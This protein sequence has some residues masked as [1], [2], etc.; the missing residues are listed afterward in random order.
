METWALLND[1]LCFCSERNLSRASLYL[2]LIDLLVSDALTL[3]KVSQYLVNFVLFS[4]L[5]KKHIGT[6]ISQDIQGYPSPEAISPK[7]N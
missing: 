4:G 7:L 2:T 1:A 5:G 3:I 6:Q